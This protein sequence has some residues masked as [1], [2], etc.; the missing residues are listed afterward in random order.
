MQNTA[1]EGTVFA[2]QR[3]HRILKIG[4]RPLVLRPALS[5]SLLLT[6]LIFFSSALR[7][8]NANVFF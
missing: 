7:K 4:L 2:W 8:H 1:S 3:G 6:G 5:N